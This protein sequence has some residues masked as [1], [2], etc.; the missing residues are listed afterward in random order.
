[1]K[2][3]AKSLNFAAAFVLLIAIPAAFA[4]GPVTPT[5]SKEARFTSEELGRIDAYLKNEI[6][7]VESEYDTKSAAP[8]DTGNLLP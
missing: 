3:S 5:K 2:P 8:V 1:M 6:S 4:D 7:R